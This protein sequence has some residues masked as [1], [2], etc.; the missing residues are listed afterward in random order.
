MIY[1]VFT[2]ALP[3]ELPNLLGDK[4]ARAHLF[5]PIRLEDS[6][7]S[8]SLGIVNKIIVI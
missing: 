8:T 3:Y 2:M 7:L 1:M 4:D 6:F 5:S